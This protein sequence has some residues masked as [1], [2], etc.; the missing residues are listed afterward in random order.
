MNELSRVINHKIVNLISN[1]CTRPKILYQDHHKSKKSCLLL[2]R[3][4]I[5]FIPTIPLKCT[6]LYAGVKPITSRVRRDRDDT[7]ARAAP[8]TCYFSVTQGSELIVTPD[9]CKFIYLYIES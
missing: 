9:S 1:N 5:Q 2:L 4:T 3:R 7:C 8:L 6:S